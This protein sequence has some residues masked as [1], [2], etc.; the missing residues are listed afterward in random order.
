VDDSVTEEQR[1]G[2]S[3]VVMSVTWE[4]GEESDRVIGENGDE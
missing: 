1:S 3:D 2:R 4:Q